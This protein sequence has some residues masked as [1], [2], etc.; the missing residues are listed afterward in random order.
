M[1]TFAFVDKDGFAFGGGMGRVLLAGAVELPSQFTIDD[2]ASLWL[3]NDEWQRRPQLPLAVANEFGFH[4]DGLP[5]PTVT[6]TVRNCGTGQ[7]DSFQAAFPDL[8]HPLPD[9]S[10]FEVEVSGPRPWLGSSVTI[11]RGTGSA[12]IAAQVL[13]RAKAA[14]VARINDAIGTARL[15]YV[16]DIPGQQ[17]IY[18]E[19]Q[20]E[21]RAYLTAVPVPVALADYPLLA[22]EVGVTAPTAWQLAQVWANKSVLFKQVAAITERLRMKASAAIAA[23]LNEADVDA[24]VSAAM[25][26]LYEGPL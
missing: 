16:T 8:R 11:V 9:N 15:K 21:A 2:L 1:I 20:A 13:V 22:A 12:E 7:E 14:A 5:D 4:I 26:T 19:K 24:A 6:I 17:T 25:T 23:A 10:T 18:T 3:Q